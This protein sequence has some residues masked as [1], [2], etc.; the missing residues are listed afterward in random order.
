MLGS[1]RNHAKSALCTG[2][3]LYW[4]TKQSLSIGDSFVTFREIASYYEQAA[5][6]GIPEAMNSYALLVED[7][8]ADVTGTPDPETAAGWYHLSAYSGYI[9]AIENLTLVLS[10]GL[11]KE[12]VLPRYSNYN[13][14][15]LLQKEVEIYTLPDAINFITQYI[16]DKKESLDPVRIKRLFTNLTLIE[17]FDPAIISSFTFNPKPEGTD[18]KDYKTSNKKSNIPSEK[19]RIHQEGLLNKFDPLPVVSNVDQSGPYNSN[20][21]NINNNNKNKNY[22]TDLLHMSASSKPSRRYVDSSLQHS[23]GKDDDD[24]DDLIHMS[25][26]S[27]NKSILPTKNLSLS[28]NTGMIPA[29]HPEI[30]RSPAPEKHK[31]TLK[32]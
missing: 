14:S 20:N 16:E 26:P 17:S 3:I 19:N 8:R 24:D 29:E 13:S 30:F 12:Y 32:V 22:N 18:Q 10:S 1:Q 2:N 25:K 7:G 5:R 27:T 6:E 31:K 15:N 11:V 21:E 23:H 4:V 9:D 28:S